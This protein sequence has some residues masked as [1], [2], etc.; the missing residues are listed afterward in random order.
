MPVDGFELAV[1]GAVQH[2]RKFV[3]AGNGQQIGIGEIQRL[4]RQGSLR[5]W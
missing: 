3:A 5:P 4:A 1:M 2:D